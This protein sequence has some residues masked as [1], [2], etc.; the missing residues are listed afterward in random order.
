M[1]LERHAH[2]HGIVPLEVA[3]LEQP[4]IH[5]VVMGLEQRVPIHALQGAPYQGLHAHF[6]KERLLA[7]HALQGAPCQ[8]LHAHC[9]HQEAPN[10]DAHMEEH[11]P[12]VFVYCPQG[13][14]YLLGV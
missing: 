11:N 10:M 14:V 8:G 3:S 12:T 9:L 6:L 1:E 2:A 4:V 7:I 5:K 13:S